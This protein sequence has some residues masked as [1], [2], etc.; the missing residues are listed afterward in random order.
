V[1]EVLE[2]LEL[3]SGRFILYPANFWPHKNHRMLITA[4]A[5]YRSWHPESDLQLV[6]TGTPDGEMDV[7][8]AATQTMGLGETVVLTGFVSSDDLAALY[9]SCR[10]LIF[11]SLYEGFG[12]P[13]V[14]AMAFGKPVLCSN[15]TSLPEIVGD[16]ALLFDPRKP[17]EIAR[18]IEAVDGDANL[19]HSL[20]Q[21]G[22]ERATQFGDGASLADAYLRIF[23]ELVDR[24]TRHFADALHGVYP[25]GWVSRC[26]VVSYEGSPSPRA[27]DLVLSAPDWLPS[28]DVTIVVRYSASAQRESYRV[29]R[30]QHLPLHLELAPSGGVVELQLWPVFVPAS[31]GFGQDDREL[32]CVCE[33]A[34]LVGP[35]G[36]VDLRETSLPAL[37]HA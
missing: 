8:H 23:R 37:V 25:D 7:I 5:L 17:D 36:S 30:G 27:L 29:Q 14:E 3:T 24:N 2:R 11:P 28:E 1:A 22:R 10:A 31:L 9:Q 12:M 26:M 20:V 13:V 16:A 6:C 19:R 18:S 35:S 4:F 21:R 15:L 34:R 33:V 32:G